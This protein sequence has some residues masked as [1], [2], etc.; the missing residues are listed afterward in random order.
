M[1]SRLAVRYTLWVDANKAG[2]LVISLL[3]AAL[4]L[5]AA[6]GLSVDDVRG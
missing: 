6:L 2:V 4:G 1:P 5:Y 3:L